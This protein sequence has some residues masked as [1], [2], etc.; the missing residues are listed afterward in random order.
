LEEFRV[1]SHISGRL[2]RDELF[3]SVNDGDIDTVILAIT[4]MQ[5]RL[6]GKRLD[7]HFFVEEI[8]N[9]VVEGC[10]YLLASD[11]DMATVGGFALTSWESG[12]GDIAFMP[13]FTTLRRVPWHEKTAIVFADVETVAGE[14]VAP[15]P[16]QI[17]QQQVSRLAERGWHGLTGTELEFIVFHDTYEE[18]WKSGYRNM[19]PVNLYNVDYSLQ[20]T[21]RVE[22]LLGRIRRSMSGAGMVVESVKGECNFG[23]HEIAFKY[24][25]LVDKC[26]EHGLF[27]LGAKEIASQEGFSLTFM[28]K[29]DER[30][31]N[32]CHIHLSLRDESNQPVFAGDEEH[33]FSPVFQHFLAGQVAYARE[34]SL[35]LAPNINSYKRFVEG[36]FAP[37][38][39]LWGIDNRTCAFRVVGHGPSVRVECRIP[40]GDVN[41]YLAVAALVAAGLRGVEESLPLAPAFS[42]NAYVADAL[43][44]P[45]SLREAVAL[46]DASAVAREAFGDEVVDHYVRAGRVEVEAFDAAVTDWERYRG[47]ER[48]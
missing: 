36:S 33:G 17:L 13:D 47:F 32:S 38:A 45:T 9:G 1:S 15:S 19:S 34:L 6:Q 29:Y 42:G 10:S 23:Q 30:E 5:G 40:G 16:R 22:P 2:T 28:A 39:L 12:Y 25:T 21:S 48:L 20:G 7:A 44:V 4:D 31:G 46:F 11:V 3:Q 41:Q 18:A 26:D 27:K 37:T 24:H 14:P 8:G 43:R 35:F